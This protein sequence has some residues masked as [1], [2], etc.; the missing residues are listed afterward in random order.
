MHAK[1]QYQ[2]QLQ[3]G[4]NW[5]RLYVGENPLR[6]SFMLLGMIHQINFMKYLAM[7]FLIFNVYWGP[8][9]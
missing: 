8:E 7:P 6:E 3:L 1:K 9:L 2:T 4:N 5:L